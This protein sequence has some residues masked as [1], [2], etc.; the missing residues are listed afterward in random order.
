[1]DDWHSI[2]VDQMDPDSAI[3]PVG[4]LFIVCSPSSIPKVWIRLRSSFRRECSSVW[5]EHFDWLFDLTSQFK[6]VLARI[7]IRPCQK[8][9]MRFAQTENDLVAFRVLMKSG[10][11]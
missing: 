11:R 9:L 5:V 4:L 7:V 8:Q 10:H 3:H 2:M 1:M 6:D